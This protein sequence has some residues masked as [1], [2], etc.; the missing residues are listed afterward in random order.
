MEAEASAYDI[1]KSFEGGEIDFLTLVSLMVDQAQQKISRPQEL[2]GYYDATSSAD[3]DNIF[4]W[5]QSAHRH[6]YLD[7]QQLQ[8]IMAEI[9]PILFGS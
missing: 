8:Q 2:R 6:R 4:F 5:L 1:I 9:H 7:D 3:H